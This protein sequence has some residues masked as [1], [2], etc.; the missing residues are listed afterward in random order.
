MA[1]IELPEVEASPENENDQSKAAQVAKDAGG[2]TGE[3]GPAPADSIDEQEGPENEN[4]EGTV[5]G[6]GGLGAF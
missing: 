2:N 3:C 4:E 1:I 5:F 6:P